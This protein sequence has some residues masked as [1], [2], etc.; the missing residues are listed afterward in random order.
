MTAATLTMVET[1]ENEES[2]AAPTMVET[3]RDKEAAAALA[4]VEAAENEGIP[5][6]PAVLVHVM[7][8]TENIE[9]ATTAPASLAE[10]TT[11]LD[12]NMEVLFRKDVKMV[13]KSQKAP[14]PRREQVLRDM[15][16][17]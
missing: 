17:I 12:G 3:A 2:A 9:A 5:A 15:I 16:S 10:G 7:G 1:N 11:P 13:L 6:A 4:V 14:R 8:A